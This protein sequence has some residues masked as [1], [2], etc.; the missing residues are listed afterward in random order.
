MAIHSEFSQFS[1]ISVGPRDKD[2]FGVALRGINRRGPKQSAGSSHYLAFTDKRCHR[3]VAPTRAEPKIAH[4]DNGTSL[5]LAG[6]F[7]K[8]V[9]GDFEN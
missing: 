9:V 2:P 8:T 6:G 3:K 1:K 4:S 7:R 5:D